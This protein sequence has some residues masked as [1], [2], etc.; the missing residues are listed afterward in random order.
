MDR[1]CACAK[2]LV[3]VLVDVMLGGFPGVMFRVQMMAVG[4]VRVMAGLLVIP[5]FV[6]VRRVAVMLRRVLVMFRCLAMMFSAL[7]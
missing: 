5:G 1:R 3:T 7:F 2:L 4:D 6:M